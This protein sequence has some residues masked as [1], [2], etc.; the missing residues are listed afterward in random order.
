VGTRASFVKPRFD[1][2]LRYAVIRC[3]YDDASLGVD[4][5]PVRIKSSG[6]HPEDRARNIA[7]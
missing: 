3:V 6:G 7:L 1:H 5:N 4:F 2:G